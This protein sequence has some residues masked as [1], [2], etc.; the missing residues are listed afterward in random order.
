M[1]GTKVYCQSFEQCA[2]KGI[3]DSNIMLFNKTEDGVYQIG[4]GDDAKYF[5]SSSLMVAGDEKACSSL[6]QCQGILAA[7]QDGKNFRIGDKLYSSINDFLSGKNIQKR[8]YTIEEATK[9]SKDTGNKIMLR[10]K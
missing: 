7:I 5:A 4:T 10:Y 2:N 9:L 3:A 1:S 8:I 6:E